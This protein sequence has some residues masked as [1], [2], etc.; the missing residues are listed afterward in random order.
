MTDEV[1]RARRKIHIEK[2]HNLYS[3]PNIVMVITLRKKAWL[4]YAARKEQVRRNFSPKNLRGPLEYSGVIL[5][6]FCRHVS[7]KLGEFVSDG[8]L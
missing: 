2:L 1:R 7:I 8:I 3:S 6:L 5:R 4:G